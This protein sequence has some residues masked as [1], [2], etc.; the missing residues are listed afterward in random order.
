MPAYSFIEVRTWVRET[1]ALYGLHLSSRR[2]KNVA[3]RWII[4]QELA[5]DGETMNPLTHSDPTGAAATQ[6]LLTIMREVAA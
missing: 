1:A 4:E 5:L 6:Q 2:C 3:Y